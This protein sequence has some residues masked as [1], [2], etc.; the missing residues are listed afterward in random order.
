M[1]EKLR[2]LK[3]DEWY[4]RID[5]TATHGVLTR[6]VQRAKFWLVDDHSVEIVKLTLQGD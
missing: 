4:C 1:T 2:E 6:S 5:D 3:N